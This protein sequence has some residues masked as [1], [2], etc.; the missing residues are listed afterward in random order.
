MVDV[1]EADGLVNWLSDYCMRMIRTGAELRNTWH[2]NS[3]LQKS[4][5]RRGG[6]MEQNDSL[7]D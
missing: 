2:D 1:M 6:T 7:K 3:G 4:L 5:R